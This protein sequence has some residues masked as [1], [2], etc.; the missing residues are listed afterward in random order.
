MN[1]IQFV[2]NSLHP[3]IH[4]PNPFINGPGAANIPQRAFNDLPGAHLN[5]LLAVVPPTT[6]EVVLSY[7]P[8]IPLSRFA[9]PVYSLCCEWL[10]PRVMNE[11]LVYCGVTKALDCVV[12]VSPKADVVGLEQLILQ[13]PIVAI[14]EKIAE[15]HII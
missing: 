3:V 10:R 15:L 8:Y 5:T 2:Y 11:E 7:L 14:L 9:V 1:S 12:D 4:A 6:A 13:D